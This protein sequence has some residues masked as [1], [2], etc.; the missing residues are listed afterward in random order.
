MIE[1]EIAELRR[2]YRKEKSNIS[3]I[4]GCFVN[5]QKEIISKFDQ[6]LGLMSED[7][8]DGLLSV[9]KKTLTGNIGRNL[10][11]IDFSARDVMEGDAHKLL[12]DLRGCELRDEALV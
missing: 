4:C 12:T 6:S 8:A 11:E 1:K 10:I 2:R 9:L 5:E 7:D 3:R